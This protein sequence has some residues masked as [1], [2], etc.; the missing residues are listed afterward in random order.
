MSGYTVWR[1]SGVPVTW[2]TLDNAITF[3]YLWA[4][5]WLTLFIVLSLKLPDLDASDFEVMGFRGSIA[6]MCY[7][8]FVRR[9]FD[10]D[11]VI[12]VPALAIFAWTAMATSFRLMLKLCCITCE[13]KDSVICRLIP[14]HFCLN[15]PR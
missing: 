11:I 6:F 14:K 12:L 10:I 8:I 2:L 1:R 9:F 3:V 5:L 13:I 15:H 7:S 4:A